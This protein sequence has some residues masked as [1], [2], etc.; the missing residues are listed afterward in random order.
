MQT[1]GVV[2][3]SRPRGAHKDGKVLSR[4]A[5]CFQ[6][7]VEHLADHP[8]PSMLANL[9]PSGAKHAESCMIV[10][11]MHAELW[12]TGAQLGTLTREVTC[13]ESKDM[14]RD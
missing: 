13:L 7:Q 3:T 10:I 14:S 1:L 5:G 9:H 2:S 11:C 12:L 6:L 4:P 8:A